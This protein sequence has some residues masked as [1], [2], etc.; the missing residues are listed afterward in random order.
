MCVCV[1]LIYC[2]LTGVLTGLLTGL[3]PSTGRQETWFLGPVP[4]RTCPV[5]LDKLFHLSEL[6]LNM[7]VLGPQKSQSS[8]QILSSLIQ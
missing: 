2:L 1:C 6:I 5:I 3:C 8:L 4:L 7:K